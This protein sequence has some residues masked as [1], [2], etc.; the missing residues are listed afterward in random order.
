MGVTVFAD[1]NG[2]AVSVISPDLP[3]FQ[4]IS[5]IELLEHGLG[6]HVSGWQGWGQLT[7]RAGVDVDSLWSDVLWALVRGWLV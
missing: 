3:M 4:P 1:V 2:V 6:H 7:T 5:S